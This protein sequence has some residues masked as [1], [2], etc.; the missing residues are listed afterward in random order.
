MPETL[1]AIIAGAKKQSLEKGQAKY[2][3]YFVKL[4]VLYADYKVMTD[5]ILA[6]EGNDDCIVKE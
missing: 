3:T 4:N 5:A 1:A 2:R 6:L